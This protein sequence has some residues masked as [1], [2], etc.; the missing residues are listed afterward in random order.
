MRRLIVGLAA[1]VWSGAAL[2]DNCP[3]NTT[4]LG[5]ARVLTVDARTTPKV[6]RKQF[7]H[8]LPLQP[9]E[10]VLTFDDGPLP[11]TT[12]RVLEALRRECVKATFFMVGQ[13]AA[14]N[15]A[16]ARHV[17]A[18]GHSIGYHTYSHRLLDRIPRAAAESEIVRGFTAVDQALYGR[19]S[20]D[21]AGAFFR[22]PGFAS[23][24]ALLDELTRRRI[25][26]FG[27]D[28]WASDWNIMSPI[29]EL[30]LLMNRLRTSGGGILLLHDTKA[31]TAAMLPAFLRELKRGGYRIVQVMPAQG[32][33]LGG[34]PMLTKLPH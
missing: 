25:V 20:L 26:V 21:P 16:L 28:L 33:T 15:P 6:G 23:S 7:P 34:T 22:F 5:V 27:A 24:P 14:A 30:R 17:L 9:K 8:T 19:T 32:T 3:G 29:E 31:R 18:D 2:A 12:E 1:L 13:Q 4:A 11:G 10:I